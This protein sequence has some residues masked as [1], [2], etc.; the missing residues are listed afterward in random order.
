LP[1]QVRDSHWKRVH[2]SVP[3]SEQWPL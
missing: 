2:Q 3:C 1:L